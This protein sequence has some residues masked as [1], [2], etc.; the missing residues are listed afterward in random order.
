MRLVCVGRRSEQGER[1]DCRRTES[2]RCG[3]GARNINLGM[4]ASLRLYVIGFQKLVTAALSS[5]AL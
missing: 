1:E 3:N 2:C 5:A 4:V